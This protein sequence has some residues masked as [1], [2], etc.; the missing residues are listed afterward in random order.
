MGEEVAVGERP[1]LVVED[2]ND[3]RQFTQ[4]ALVVHGYLVLTAANGRVAL[5]V[6]ARERPG[7]ILLDLRMPIMDGWTFA[8][9]LKERGVQVPIVVM[10]AER[11]SA[12]WAAEIGAAA[13][14]AKPFDLD[15]LLAVVSRFD[16]GAPADPSPP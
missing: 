9:T 12:E 16:L 4:A 10:T 14:L 15:R 3:I 11:L 5:E 7:L 6:L 8:R 1:I 2:D 13:H